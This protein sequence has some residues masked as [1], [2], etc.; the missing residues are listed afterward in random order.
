MVGQARARAEEL[1]AEA[2]KAAAASS[3]VAA[4]EAQLG[5]LQVGGAGTGMGLRGCW[6]L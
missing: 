3:R 2:A 4:L 1:E 6:V 5:E